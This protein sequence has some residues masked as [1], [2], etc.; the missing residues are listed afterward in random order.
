MTRSVAASAVATWAMPPP[1]KQSSHS[2]T[3]AKP[4]ASAARTWRTRSSGGS[5]GA[6]DESE[7]H[8]GHRYVTVPDRIGVE[9]RA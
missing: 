1:L 4:A 9:G 7:V 3:S 2:Q 8:V 6:H 5:S